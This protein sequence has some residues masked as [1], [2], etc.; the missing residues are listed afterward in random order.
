[1]DLQ[2]VGI[3]AIVMNTFHLMQ[4]PGSST[5][6][7]LGG[8][9]N[10]STWHG[11]IITDSGGFQAY[12]VIR[13]Y[14]KMGNITDKGISFKR[15]AD[16][17]K[18]QL[19]PEKTI[20]LQISFGADVVICLD[21][22]TH[23]DDSPDIQRQAVQRTIKWAK[24]CRNEFDRLINDKELPLEQTPKLFAVVQGGGDLSLRKRCAE[25]LIEI[26]F[27]G[28]GFGGWPLD[29]NGQL[30]EDILAYTHQLIPDK[31]PTHALGVG[32]PKHIATCYAL[33]YDL[34]DSSL[35]TRDA[36]RGR[37]YTFK[38]PTSL[39]GDWFKFLYIEDDKYI[40]DSSP[41]SEFCTC[42]TCQQYTRGYLNHLFKTGETLFF[43]LATIHNLRFM[44]MLE[45][46]LR[47][48]NVSQ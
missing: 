25:E 41:L 38:T 3:Q 45:A 22:C 12:S 5:I 27:D 8:I 1:M 43:R 36:R 26:G 33:G 30:L 44:V 47:G 37:L 2:A 40:K 34:F 10:M 15:S 35:P 9:H 14:P 23:V 32:H 17:R 24:R 28:Y 31:F 18:F 19:T 46:R 13:E 39:H 16:K 4:K 29:N 7:A 21:D 6:R 42:S 20:Q 48:E 11:P